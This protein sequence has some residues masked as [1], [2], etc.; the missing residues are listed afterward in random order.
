MRACGEGKFSWLADPSNTVLS[1]FYHFFVE[2]LIRS[3]PAT[4]YVAIFLFSRTRKKASDTS[5][6]LGLFAQFLEHSCGLVC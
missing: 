5:V 6:V 4:A 3:S 2:L 1:P